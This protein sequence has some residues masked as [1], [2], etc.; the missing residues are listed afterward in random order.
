[1]KSKWTSKTVWVGAFTLAVGVANLLAGS[2]LIAQYPQIVAAAVSISGALGIVLRFLTT[3][4][5]R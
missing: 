3:K 1:M 5:I 2:E 4:P